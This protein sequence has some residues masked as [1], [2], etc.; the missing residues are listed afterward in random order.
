MNKRANRTVI[1][2]AV[3]CLASTPLLA[4]TSGQAKSN[5]DRTAAK[6]LEQERNA[7]NEAR[8]TGHDD[9][10]I[11]LYTKALGHQPEW[12][13]GRWFLST[14]LYEKERFPEARDELRRFVADEPETGPAWAV[15]GMSEYQTREY[16]RALEHMQKGLAKGLGER[17]ELTRSVFYFIAV[18]LTRYERYSDAMGLLIPMVKS[19]TETD[20][21]VEP[22]GLA[23]LRLPYLPAEIPH[24]RRELIQMAGRATLAIDSQRTEEAESLFQRMVKG[25]PNE[26]GVH[27]LYGAYLMDVRPEEGIREMQR[28]L[29]ISPSHVGARL[30][31]AEE[32]VKEQKIDEALRLSE[33][34]VKLEPKN[35]PPHMMLGESLV[36]K[37]EVEKGIAELELAEKL[38]PNT[39][40]THWDL[41]RAYSSAGRSQ[42]AKREKETIE[43]LSRPE[44]RP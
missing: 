24:D 12:K 44:A 40:R 34:A 38:A 28:E 2:S 14:L 20:S 43:E 26:P 16:P 39:V 19:S 25:Y 42:D 8:D 37:G 29:E 11:R 30:R 33:E 17:K 9:E 15:L 1:L 3:L 35:G 4:E 23:T 18:L 6:S 41:L 21:L 31:M 13:E 32:H 10:A 27:F 36:A 22:I 5:S 7:A